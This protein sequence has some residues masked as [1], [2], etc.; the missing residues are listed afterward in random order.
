[1]DI[2]AIFL[3]LP[4]VNKI[5]VTEDGNFHL[6]PNYGGIPHIR[7]DAGEV[8]ENNPRPKGRPKSIT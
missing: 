8:S 7:E 2:K 3:A 6:H 1:M 5:W 4:H